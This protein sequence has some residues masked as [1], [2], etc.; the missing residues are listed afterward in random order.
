MQLYDYMGQLASGASFQGTLEAENEAG[1]RATLVQMGVRTASLRPA[2]RNAFVSPLSLD[3]FQ[4]LNEQIAALTRGGV[5]LEEGLRQAAADVASR[6]LKRL[7]LDL[8]GDLARGVPLPKALE[9]LEGRFPT[10]YANVVKAGLQS[11]DLGGT[12]Y[13]LAAHLRL[14]DSA[15]RAMLELAAYP[16]AVLALALGVLS[17]L[18]RVLV[19]KVAELAGDLMGGVYPISGPGSPPPRVPLFSQWMFEAAR[20]WPTIEIVLW[21]LLG[22]TVLALVTNPIPLGRTLREWV[23]R[24]IPG[25]KR[26]YVAST[27]ARFSHTCALG[28][29][30]GLPLPELIS[31]GGAA[32]GSHYLDAATRRAA[33]RLREG[34]SLDVAAAAEPLIPALWTCVVRAA[35]PRGELAAALTDLARTYESRAESWVRTVRILLGPLLLLVVGLFLGLVIT[36]IGATFGYLIASLTNQ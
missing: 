35:A 34:Q 1:A 30:S 31:A 28:A 10:Q 2:K 5:P 19:P 27:L 24:R 18:L 26:A 15:R 8:A 21:S 6:K 3:D 36:G 32:S 29:Y 7:L 17:L 4:F 33:Q 9:A 25:V 13:G 23:I 22:L 14:T 16:L 11:G 12:L 20:Y